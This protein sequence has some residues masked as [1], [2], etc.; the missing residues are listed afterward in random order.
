MKINVSNYKK[1]FLPIECNV[2]YPNHSNLT[3]GGFLLVQNLTASGGNALHVTQALVLKDAMWLNTPSVSQ[4]PRS[5]HFPTKAASMD[6]AG[7]TSHW[8]SSFLLLLRWEHSEALPHVGKEGVARASRR[9]GSVLF[10]VY[11]GRDSSF[12]RL[13]ARSW[14]LFIREIS[15]YYWTKIKQ[16]YQ[17]TTKEFW[18]RYTQIS[19][20]QGVR[21]KQI[22]LTATTW[23][24]KNQRQNTIF[25]IPALL[26]LFLPPQMSF[27][28]TLLK[29]HS[30]FKVLL[31][32]N[33]CLK[34]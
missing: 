7:N 30:P 24:F 27:F 33:L 32:D 14:I 5:P 17:N 10:L 3:S 9:S 31:N 8:V 13:G 6:K 25:L 26:L 34:L 29:C 19:H 21:K 15:G 2:Q 1:R 23:H 18:T 28:F 12:G 4:K 20:L 16:A 11:W 22:N